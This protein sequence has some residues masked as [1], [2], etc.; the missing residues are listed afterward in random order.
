[1]RAETDVLH[2][3]PVKESNTRERERVCMC[4]KQQECKREQKRK[5]TDVPEYT[6]SE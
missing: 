1:M 3:Y 6:Q 4:G 5:G 2:G